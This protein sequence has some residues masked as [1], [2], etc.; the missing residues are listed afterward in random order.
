[1]AGLER[2]AEY[3]MRVGSWYWV[4]PERRATMEVEKIRNLSDDELALEGRKAAEQLF[5]LRFQMKLGQTEGVKK[6]RDLKKDVA[7]IN[8]VTRERELGIHALVAPKHHAAAEAE[9]AEREAEAGASVKH[10][11][12]TAAKPAKKKAAKKTVTSHKAS[13]RSAA[14]RKSTAKPSANK[15]PASRS[16]SVKKG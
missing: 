14:A 9:R 4:R 7:R 8:T 5:R 15:K 13:G 16:T 6:L 11:K 1:L 2:L 10:A 3:E 12:K